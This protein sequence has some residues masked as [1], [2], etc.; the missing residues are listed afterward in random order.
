MTICPHGVWRAYRVCEFCD[1][2]E[3]HNGAPAWIRLWGEDGV[4]CWR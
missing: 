1:W 4:Y 2:D 3:G